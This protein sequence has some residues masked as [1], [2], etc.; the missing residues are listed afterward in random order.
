MGKGKSKT[1]WVASKLFKILWTVAFSAFTVFLFLFTIA[2][3]GRQYNGLVPSWQW[4]QNFPLVTEITNLVATSGKGL[5]PLTGMT[6][7]LLGLDV[8]LLYC[9]IMWVLNKIPII[10]KII[11]WLTGIIPTLAMIVVV[12]GLV[13]IFAPIG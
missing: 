12:I 6:I 10:G 8:L 5:S 4:T 13:L 11:K 3:L 1:G 2:Y 9:S 7:T